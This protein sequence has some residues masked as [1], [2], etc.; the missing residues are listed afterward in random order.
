VIA[1]GGEPP[2]TW[3]CRRSRWPKSAAGPEGARRGS[4][5][6][7]ASAPRRKLVGPARG[8]PPALDLRRGPQPLEPAA[9]PCAAPLQRAAARASRAP[10]ALLRRA[11]QAG[12]GLMGG[13]GYVRA[14]TGRRGPLSQPAHAG[15]C[16]PRADSHLGAD[17]PAAARAIS[18]RAASAWAFPL[19][20]RDGARLPR[21]RDG[22]WRPAADARNRGAAAARATGE[23]G[24]RYENL[25]CSCTAASLGAPLDQ[26][27][28]GPRPF[29]ERS[30]SRP[31]RGGG[32][33]DYPGARRR[34]GTWRP[35][36]DP[37]AS[38]S[39]LAGLRRRPLAAADLV[40]APRAGGSVFEI[41]ASRPPGDPRAPLPR[42]ALRR[43][44]DRE[45]TL[46]GSTRARPWRSPTGEPDR[47]Q[48]G[49]RGGRRALL[50][51]RD[52]LA[53]DVRRRQAASR[54][55]DAARATVGR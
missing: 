6:S 31:A 24:P 44:P 53:S 48:A 34:P 4:R 39:R 27:R 23:S 33:R 11:G 47:G 22:P 17:Q 7:A 35:G 42:N 51:D 16:L 43:S 55:P 29:R 10:R 36:Y 18:A 32:R 15:W 12:R 8:F 21:H 1:A 2:G 50:A 20:G 46:D 40:V 19:P 41:A 28:G 54:V 13:G 38:T 49:Q 52:R 30:L 5:S 3:W 25:A 26:P 45:R 14:G 37:A 9:R